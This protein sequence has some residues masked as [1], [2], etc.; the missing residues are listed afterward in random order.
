[1]RGRVT[2]FDEATG[3]GAVT[4]ADGVELTFH[5]VA[6]ADGSRAIAVGTEVDYEIVPGLLGRWEASGIRPDPGPP[7][8]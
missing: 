2:R 7:G 8:P 4:G 1:V 6:I 5:A 3:L